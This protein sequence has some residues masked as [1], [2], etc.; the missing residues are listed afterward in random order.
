MAAPRIGLL[1]VSF[2]GLDQAVKSSTGRRA[3]RRVAKQPVLSSNHEG[4]DRA[5]CGVVVDR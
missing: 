1:A 4:A 5:L 2:G 3:V